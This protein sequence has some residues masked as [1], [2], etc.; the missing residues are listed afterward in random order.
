MASIKSL[1]SGSFQLSVKNRLLPKTLWATF[2]SFEQAEAY[3]KQLEG[4]LA[5]G[6]V[7][8]SLLER[9]TPAREIWTVARCI[10]EYIRNNDVPV[11]DIKILDTVRP[12]LLAPSTGYLNYDWASSFTIFDTR[13]L[14]DF[15]SNQICPMCSSQRSPATATCVR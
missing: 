15:T 5:Q 3:G 2:D 14:A 10:A 13:P 7:P 6:I 1:P 12:T 8:T 11:S 4:L 9:T